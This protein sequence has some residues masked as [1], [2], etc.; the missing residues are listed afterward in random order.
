M[1]AGLRWIDGYYG[2][3]VDCLG[4]QANG[5]EDGEPGH[6]KNGVTDIDKQDGRAD[7]SCDQTTDDD[8][9]QTVT[10]GQAA[11]PI[12]HEQPQDPGKALE[13]NL[14]RVQTVRRLGE[15][16]RKVDPNEIESRK[17]EHAGCR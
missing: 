7:C 1:I 2:D 9:M 15:C 6:A 5:I 11:G 3:L 8:D 10:V 4:A 17:S 13:S 14:R 12:W 16:C